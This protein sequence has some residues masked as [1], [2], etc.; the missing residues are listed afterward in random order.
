LAAFGH[1][2]ARPDA[3]ADI[4]RH[5]ADCAACCQVL[6]GLADDSLLQR[7]RQGGVAPD[8][9]PTV[10]PAGP[11]LVAGPGAGGP[12]IPGYEILGEL[13]RGGMGVVYQAR[14]TALNRLVALKVVR[15]AE[16]AG[17]EERARFRREAEAL[18]RLQHPHIVQV[19]E[20][21]EHEGLPFL[22]LELV[23]GGSLADRLEG[24]P[25]PARPA[26]QLLETLARAI[27]AAHER[28][29]VH[30]D[31]KPA[32]VLLT[33]DG[34]PK[35]TDF[36]LAKWLDVEVG[37][38]PTGAV[39]GTPRYMAPEQATGHI[40]TIRPAAD[41]Y[42]L[43]AILYELLTGG[44]PFKGETPLETLR[45]VLSE[46]PVPPRL[47]NPRVP[48][49]LETICLKC[50]RKALGKRYASAAAL[51]E[52]LRRFLDGRPIQAR[53]ISLAERG[54]KWVWRHPARA[55]LG[56][57]SVLLAGGVL[58]GVFL[59]QQLRLQANEAEAR[60]T[61][62]R[63]E[64]ERERSIARGGALRAMM[65]GREFLDHKRLD[66][67]RAQAN[68]ALGLTR[69]D[70][71]LAD[72]KADAEHLLE[73]LDRHR[74]GQQKHRQFL[75]LRHEALFYATLFAGNIDLARNRDE[76]RA[77]ARKALALFGVTI[78]SD[79]PPAADSSYFSADLRAEL[80]ADCYELL[81]VLA[82]AEAQ[83]LPG[84]K[85]EEGRRQTEQALR[86]L[87]RAA[88]LGL[89]DTQT[90]H[91][92]RARYLAQRD[93]KQGAA[94][95]QALAAR[96]PSARAIDYFLLGDEQYRR[97]NPAEAA[98]AFEKSLYLQPNQFWAQ[99][100][101]AM[102]YL[103]LKRPE[104]AQVSLTVSLGRRPDFIPRPDF[105]WGYLLRGVAHG[106]LA[107]QA[108][109]QG[110][111]ADADF[112]FQAAEKDFETAEQ[113]QPDGLAR[114][115]FHVNRS[116]VRLRQGKFRGAKADLLEATRLKPKQYE[117]YVNLAE[118][119]EQE[120]RLDE[121]A[122]WQAGALLPG[123]AQGVVAAALACGRQRK[124]YEAVALMDQAIQL[125]PN[126]PA[127]YFSR[128]WLHLQRRAPQV[129]LRDFEQ[130][131]RLP[132]VEPQFLAKAHAERGRL[133][134]QA[135]R[136][137]DAL[138]AFDAA[139]KT[140]S[141]PPGRRAPASGVDHDAL[142]ILAEAHRG[143]AQ[144]LL[145]LAEQESDTMTKRQ[146]SEEAVRSFDRCLKIEPTTEA[147]RRRGR[148]RAELGDFVGA[149]DDFTL[150]LAV[151][152]DAVTYAA[153]GWAHVRSD[154]PR[155]ALHDFEEAIKLDR[156][157][158]EGYNGRGYVHVRAGRW[159]EAVRDAEQAAPRAA[160]DPRL[161][162]GAARVFAL[163]TGPPD[164]PALRPQYEERA[165]RLLQ[166]ALALLP[167]AAQRRLFWQRYIVPDG[168]FA[169]LHKNPA[170]RTMAR[171]YSGPAK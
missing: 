131:T 141:A 18:A 31:L 87:D 23:S 5:V 6:R 4:A 94:E 120:S 146:L 114:Y 63:L 14:H 168:D 133:L 52:D 38:T 66:E 25:K 64:Q 15:S 143:R 129:A 58:V 103:K 73:Q 32:N 81:L 88:R 151:A 69:N 29:L 124:L 9:A 109:G 162:V 149:A 82:E 42:A 166:N 96:M 126:L 112:H 102:C 152:P 111:R 140:L 22:V 48:R 19:Y 59:W 161:L 27:D 144:T 71:A 169:P 128:A 70:P 113:S 34:I 37:Q 163:A 2:T 153:R 160:R 170:F 61:R 11:D 119:Y 56:G 85:E 26:A 123:P 78:D 108:L 76:T 62:N 28:G 132:S 7:L 68:K 148:A 121:A 106:E 93:D 135:R 65:A 154:A 40:R 3:E 138:E 60:V 86:T 97:G 36:G 164:R 49:D 139:L 46:E 57:V 134:H 171:D 1:G 12:D 90:Y 74:D 159:R 17:P 75:Q 130:I 79:G 118:V 21:G 99:Y 43:G 137:G 89:G 150:A 117:A 53:P 145:M 72:V 45:Q 30:R 127:L 167:T 116:Y 35:I 13:G 147:Y 77:A 67:A 105:I 157:G 16:H 156:D 95:E 54:Y 80:T 165:L 24:S 98:A 8:G 51:A 101:L 20:V 142:A 41:V 47:L 115:A 100:F 107:A 104:E 91:L 122:R 158:G 84:H 33:A 83:P 39:V 110:R 10:P 125:E 155:L 136:Y 55:A 92:R 44:P 50:L